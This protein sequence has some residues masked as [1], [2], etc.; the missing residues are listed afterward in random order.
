MANQVAARLTGD[1]YQHLHAWLFVLELKMPSRQVRQVTLEDASAGSI[2]DVTI[3]HEAGTSQPDLFYQV[4]YH[5]DQRSAYSTDV[6]TEHKPKQSSLL[7][8]MWHTWRQLRE[9]GGQGPLEL[10]LLSNWPWDPNDKVGECIAGRDGRIKADFFA[11]TDRQDLGQL[12]TR[13]RE[14]LGATEDDF[15]AFVESLRLELGF[16]CFEELEKRVA[17]RMEYLRLRHDET[18]LLVAAGIVRDWISTGKHELSL[19]DLE[20]TLQKHDLYLPSEAERCVTIYLTSIKAQVFDLRP[21]H[22]LDWRDY[23]MGASSKKGHE[24]VD[25]ETWNSVLLRELQQLEATVNQETACR[26][27]RA[28]GLARLSAWFAFGFT[29]SDVARYTVEVDQNGRLWRTDAAPAGDF[30]L[31]TA[32]ASP[33]GETLDGDGETVAVG[34]SVTGALDEDVRAFLADRTETVASLL[35]LRPVRELG[36]DCLQTASDV[37]ALADQAKETIRT[38]VKTWKARRLL[39]FYFGPLSGACFI[40]HRLNAVCREIQIMEDQQPGY[41]PSFLLT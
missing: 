36:R 20:N 37:T 38:F 40:G 30:E 35:L 6:L 39:L 13:W 9:D 1:D 19:A 33:A 22:I 31:Q 12:R 5:V 21:D 41:A 34:I 4:K 17:E 32:S 16:H 25:A 3:R 11:A 29:F 26:L 10:H 27:V 2:D 28:R 15:K 8:K 7:E 14:H 23:F 18:A 24:L